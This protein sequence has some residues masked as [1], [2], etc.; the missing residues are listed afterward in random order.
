MPFQQLPFRRSI[1]AIAISLTCAAGTS[2]A[3][4][5]NV[6]GGCTLIN[7]INNANADA[8]T[9]GRKG[10]PAGSGADI[11]N[12]RRRQVYELTQVDN[13]TDGANGI[14]SVTSVIT[15]NG[16][17]TAVL[18]SDAQGTPNFRLFHVAAT[19]E[20]T[21]ESMTIKNGGLQNSVFQKCSP[22]RDYC[23]TIHNSYMGSGLLNKGKISL[24]NT[25][26]TGNKNLGGNGGGIANL[27]T[28]TLTNSTVSRNS[29][30]G[31]PVY[32][33]SF[34]NYGSYEG[35]FLAGGYGGGIFNGGKAV[36]T[37]STLSRN[38][39]LGGGG[40][41]NPGLLALTDSTVSGNSAVRV[42]FNYGYGGEG[43]GI[44][45]FGGKIWRIK[46]DGEKE[47]ILTASTLSGNSSSHQGGGIVNREDGT[48]TLKNMI[49][50]NSKNGDCISA[51]NLQLKG[52]NLI[53]DGSCGTILSGDPKLGPLRDN[54]GPTRTH[55]LLKDSPAI[56]AKRCNVESADQRGVARPQPNGGRCDLGAYERIPV[57]PD[58]VSSSVWPL[59]QFFKA[60]VVD[61]NI[62]GA[63][64]QAYRLV[65]TRNQIITAD[66]YR[67][68][69]RDAESCKQLSRLLW[70]IDPDGSPDK[71]DYVTGSGAGALAD[72]ITALKDTWDCQ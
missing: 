34:G 41:A 35:S 71:N 47:A 57:T 27:G 17:G 56:D 20:L 18:R 30:E 70:R 51:S 48:I 39:A 37:A 32:I 65:A 7:A 25:V 59:I 68:N 29:V 8:D 15:I 40:I 53:E 61:G 13:K 46:N 67:D 26:V 72:K 21:L 58:S 66:N 10:C 63:G 22:E 14:P 6:G 36:L 5:I 2:S 11:I 64:T 49:I 43:G 42:N 60:Q 24:I 33:S 4:V 62:I 50:A 28:L 19:G 9:D 16:N 69:G 45:N 1:L 12:L 44:L 31:N 52:V 55:A 3:A 38:S 23:N 54:G